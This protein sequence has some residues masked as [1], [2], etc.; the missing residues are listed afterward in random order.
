MIYL[1]VSQKQLQSRQSAKWS[2]SLYPSTAT[3]ERARYMD[4]I[5]Y[6]KC[7]SPKEVTYFSGMRRLH[8]APPP[9]SPSGGTN[10]VI[11]P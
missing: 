5:D 7:S 9:L 6:W 2:C 3:A 1:R 4:C 10:A 11:K 8:P